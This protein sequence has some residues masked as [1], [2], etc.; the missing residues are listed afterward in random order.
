M[1]NE[2]RANSRHYA[3]ISADGHLMM[4]PTFWVDEAPAAYRDRVPRMERFE[5]GDAWVH[6][7]QDTPSGFNWGACAG[8][9]PDQLGRWCR[10]EDVNRGCYEAS[11]RLDELDLDGVDAEVL[12]PNGGFDW[13]PPEDDRDF[14]LAVVQLY[15]DHLSGFCGTAPDRFGGCALLPSSGVDDCL[16]E[17]ERLRDRP[18]L[19]AWLL[20]TFPHGSS[21]EIT[22]DDDPVWEAIE[23]SGKP[24]TIHVSLRR[25]SEF[26]MVATALPG[27]FHF[28][29]A[30]ARML[31]FIFSGVLD[32]FPDLQVFFAEVDCGWLPYFAQ[33]ADDNYLR[34]ARSEL[35]DV[36]LARSPSDYMKGR[37][38]A[39]FITDPIAI[40]N[41]HEIGVHRMLWSSDYP[42]ITSDWPFSWRTVNATF[43]GVPDDEKHAILAGNAMRLFGFGADGR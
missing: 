27:T 11:A 30:P 40:A 26:K 16:A 37:F 35:K 24:A 14:H 39:S 31:D 12:Y 15:N 23:A 25:T 2:T 7:G 38:P 21:D 34:H 17:I 29:D 43:T 33:Q 20:T 32:R 41:R 5:Q 18:G 1:A 36:E 9:R 22:A 19:V 4:P 10:I 8:R 6:P 42:H 28:Y 13:A 3:L